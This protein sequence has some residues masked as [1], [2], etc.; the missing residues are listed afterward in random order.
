MH[1]NR[2]I[3]INRVGEYE[4]ILSETQGIN[5]NQKELDEICKS[6]NTWI[7]NRGGKQADLKNADLRGLDLRDVDLRGA[8]LENTNLEG[9]NLRYADLRGANLKN[10]NL[11][12]A[13]LKNAY[14]RDSNL[15]GANL[16]GANL[17]NANLRDSNLE[18][19]NLR[20]SNLP[21]NIPQFLVDYFNDSCSTKKELMQKLKHETLRREEAERRIDGLLNPEK[22]MYLEVEKA[23][24]YKSK[25]RNEK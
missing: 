10:A 12:G 1:R 20:D 23:L 18:G 3:C 14:L 25:Y 6:H 5:M 8:G 9:A 21:D 22:Y 17:K 24:E 11:E 4:E 19:A 15:E 16:E 2:E 7:R 13:N